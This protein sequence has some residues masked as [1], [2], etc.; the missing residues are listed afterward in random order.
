MTRFDVGGTVKTDTIA[1][2][3]ITVTNRATGAPELLGFNY[4]ESQFAKVLYWDLKGPA[5]A[6]P[7]DS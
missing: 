6:L 1:L 2:V 4:A 7:V 5:V 3:T